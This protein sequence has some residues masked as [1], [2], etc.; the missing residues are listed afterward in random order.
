M[1]CRFMHR[2][3]NQ[4]LILPFLLVLIKDLM[5]WSPVSDQ[6]MLLIGLVKQHITYTQGCRNVHYRHFD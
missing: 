3:I 5:L 2:K 6:Y 1:T 4:R